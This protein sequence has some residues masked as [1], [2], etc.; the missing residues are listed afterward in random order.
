MA[1]HPEML[2]TFFSGHHA[3]PM[4]SSSSR[5]MASRNQTLEF[6]PLSPRYRGTLCASRMLVAKFMEPTSLMLQYLCGE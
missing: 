5:W 6:S 1:R 3:H 2:A 4:L